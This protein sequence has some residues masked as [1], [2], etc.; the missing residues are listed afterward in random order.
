M[1]RQS[2]CGSIIHRL[3]RQAVIRLGKTSAI[4]DQ[5]EVALRQALFAKDRC[6][7]LPG[8]IDPGLL[9]FVAPRLEREAWVRKMHGRIGAEDVLDDALAVGL[10]EFVANTPAFLAAVR[11]ISGRAELTR[12]KG[13]IYRLAPGSHDYDSWHSDVVDGEPPRLAGMS[14]NLG[15]RGHEGGNLQFRAASSERIEFEIANTGWG[16]ATLFDISGDRKHRVTAVTGRE[17]RIAFAGW[18][19][20]GTE[21][22]FA[23][24][25]QAAVPHAQGPRR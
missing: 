21:D 7:L 24:L 18:F 6:V 23:S 1:S 11:R 8:L 10:L 17:P 13:R 25:R 4:I 20:S 15:A 2:R 14:V 22:Y 19:T 5:D 16:D 3:V 12:F 9:A